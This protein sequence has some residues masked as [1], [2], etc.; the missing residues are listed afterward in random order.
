M[1]IDEFWE[2][3]DGVGKDYPEMEEKCERLGKALRGL[4]AAQIE[5]FND[6]FTANLHELNTWLIREAAN[7]QWGDEIT[8]KDFQNYCSTII[9]YGRS[10]FE[11]TFKSPWWMDCQVKDHANVYIQLF[12]QI[13]AHV[14]KEKT[15]KEL[16]CKK[17]PSTPHGPELDAE[18]NKTQLQ[19]VRNS[20]QAEKRMD[21]EK[22]KREAAEQ[23][24]KESAAR[25]ELLKSVS[26]EKIK[27]AKSASGQGEAKLKKSDWDGAIVD[28]TKAVEANPAFAEAYVNRGNAK[29]GKG[30]LAG[31]IADYTKAIEL[32]PNFLAAYE[33]RFQARLNFDDVEGAALDRYEVK[34]IRESIQY[35]RPEKL[36]DLLDHEWLECHKTWTAMD[37]DSYTTYTL[38]LYYSFTLTSLAAAEQL[39]KGVEERKRY[40]VEIVEKD[41]PGYMTWRVVCS[42]QKQLKD[43]SDLMDWVTEMVD[44]SAEFGC[45]TGAWGF[46]HFDFEP[47]CSPERLEELEAEEGEDGYDDG[48]SKDGNDDRW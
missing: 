38:P 16:A 40:A 30:D 32:K 8:D 19:I 15:K 7:V 12:S 43:P 37:L 29:A 45:E 48:P 31:A 6:H 23:K 1:T 14:Y 27:E 11:K 3:L 41:I 18:E 21:A 20:Y 2:I 4:S 34:R 9:S 39:K 25:T 5:S 46:N 36:Q 13:A 10:D 22:E 47:I 33:Q 35:A 26:A 17:Y 28:F 42:T 24:Q 44:L